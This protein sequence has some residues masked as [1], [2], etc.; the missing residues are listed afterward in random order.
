MSVLVP[1]T[2]CF[3]F[4]LSSLKLLAHSEGFSQEGVFVNVLQGYSWHIYDR[5]GLI[6]TL[7]ILSVL[8]SSEKYIFFVWV[9]F[10]RFKESLQFEC[11]QILSTE[12]WTSSSWIL[13][14]ARSQAG[15]AGLRAEL[16]RD[17]RL[18]HPVPGQRT[19]R[20]EPAG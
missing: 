11:C 4:S 10:S 14:P 13:S 2:F 15:G 9:H 16:Q 19:A 3:S 12:V 17:L 8:L 6:F 20:A 18:Q 7:C 5:I 1:S